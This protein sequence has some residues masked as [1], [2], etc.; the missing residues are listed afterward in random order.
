MLEIYSTTWLT[1]S[2]DVSLSPECK[3]NSSL[4]F[5]TVSPHSTT[6]TTESP[7]TTTYHTTSPGEITPPP[8]TT[9]TEPLTN[10]PNCPEKY[11]ENNGIC[12]AN[13]GLFLCK[14]PS[15]YTGDKCETKV[16]KP[17]KKNSK[18]LSLEQ[19]NISM[20]LISYWPNLYRH[21]P[22]FGYSHSWNRFDCSVGWRY[23]LGQ[24]KELHGFHWVSLL[25][26]HE[27]LLT[28]ADQNSDQST[29]VFSEI[30]FRTFSNNENER[31]NINTTNSATN[32]LFK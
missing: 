4:T 21:W 27:A 30:S 7:T 19:N 5:P 12:A 6:S 23:L 31:I 20:T 10:D 8:V 13:Q 15:G 22:Y 29:F 32:P 9:T 2:D 16:E 24:K 17:K 25:S 1:N 18:F 14:C 3:A 11:C 28:L 26:L